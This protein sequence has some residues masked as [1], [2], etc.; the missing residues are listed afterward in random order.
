MSHGDNDYLVNMLEKPTTNTSINIIYLL[1]ITH[2]LVG[3]LQH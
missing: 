2:M 1:G 3:S